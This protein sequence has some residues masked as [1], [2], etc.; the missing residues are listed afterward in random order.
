MEELKNSETDQD[1][2]KCKKIQLNKGAFLMKSMGYSS[3]N[4]ISYAKML[5]GI[6]SSLK[7]CFC[8]F[9]ID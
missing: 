6:H 8:L 4:W 3:V 9:L 5:L 7:L 1:K 2:E